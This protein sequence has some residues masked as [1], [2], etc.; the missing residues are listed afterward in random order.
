MQTTLRA[1]ADLLSRQ[2]A[3]FA[4]SFEREPYL[5]GVRV[6][7]LGNVIQVYPDAQDET[8]IHEQKSRMVVSELAQEGATYVREALHVFNNALILSL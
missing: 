3:H 2:E 1:T 7:T 4:Q 8:R 5:G 6:L